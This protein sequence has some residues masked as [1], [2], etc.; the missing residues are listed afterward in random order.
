MACSKHLYAITCTVITVLFFP[1]KLELIPCSVQTIAHL[2]I[3]SVNVAITAALLKSV[4]YVGFSLCNV[5]FEILGLSV[6]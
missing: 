3:I 5:M 1:L 6:N 4:C 2:D